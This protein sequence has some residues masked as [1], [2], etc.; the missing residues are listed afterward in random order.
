MPDTDGKQA[1]AP[2]NPAT[3]AAGTD[4]LRS[5]V[6]SIVH[7]LNGALN[8]L[9]LNVE[10]L[11]KMPA[12]AAD[13]GEEAARRARHLASLRRA[14]REIQEVVE[15]QLVPLGRADASPTGAR[16]SQE[17]PPVDSTGSPSR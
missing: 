8:N 10:L 16:S 15:H 14:V 6:R 5:S 17:E 1:E 13:A 2:P 3:G 4:P 11:D 9:I 12:G 7:G